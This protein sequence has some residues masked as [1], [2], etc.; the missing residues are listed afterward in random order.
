MAR[1]VVRALVLTG[2]EQEAVG[3]VHVGW[4]VSGNSLRATVRD[5]GPGELTRCRLGPRRVHERLEA[6]GGR[7]EVDAV[8]GRGTTLTANLPLGSTP[9]APAEPLA[10]LGSRALEVLGHLARGHRDRAVAEDPRISESTVRFH[11]ANVLGKPGVSPLGE[12]ST[13]FH[14]VAQEVPAAASPSRSRPRHASLPR[15]SSTTYTGRG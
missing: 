4:R 5:D 11:V 9:P 13:V 3:R 14:A 7:L 15:F 1:A 12:A 8:P 2:L 6:L 10:A